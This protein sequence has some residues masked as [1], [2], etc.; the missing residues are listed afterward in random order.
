MKITGLIVCVLLLGSFV[1][2]AQQSLKEVRKVNYYGIDFS[3]VKIYRA[4]E[5]EAQFLRAFKAI[6]DLTLLEDKKYDFAKF[7]R[8]SVEW[9]SFEVAD[10]RNFSN[11]AFLLPPKLSGKQLNEIHLSD[12]E[13]G[14]VVGNYGN[15][16]DGVGVVI[17]GVLLNKEV[18]EGIYEVVFFD[19][20]SKEIVFHKEVRG[21]ARG[22]GLRNYWAYSVYDALK[23]WK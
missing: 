1:A 21:K 8:K 12:A 15:G 2:K 6:N 13:L 17:I 23:R 18:P 9:K 11:E 20:Q 14:E 4:Q 10:Q 7:F 16:D 22:F 3:K 5:S 19:V